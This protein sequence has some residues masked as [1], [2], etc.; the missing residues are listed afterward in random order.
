M[1]TSCVSR[2]WTHPCASLDTPV[3]TVWQ[4]GHMDH[5]TSKI[6]FQH[7]QLACS[8]VGSTCLGFKQHEIGTHHVLRS[9][10]VME[11]CLG[12]IPVYTIMLIGRWSSNKA[13][14]ALLKQR[15]KK[16]LSFCFWSFLHIL[17]I[18]PRRISSEDPRQSSHHN[19]VEMRKNIGCGKSRQVQLQSFS[20][21]A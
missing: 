4:N 5:I 18:A 20:L 2:I 1:G 13:E 6:I 3:C 14:G 9:G 11:M 10:A 21:Y 7:L 16:M 12:E 17:D 15:H 19:N 8:T